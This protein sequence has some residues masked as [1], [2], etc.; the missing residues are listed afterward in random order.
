MIMNTFLIPVILD[1]SFLNQDAFVSFM[2]QESDLPREDSR[3][4]EIPDYN[5]ITLVH[6]VAPAWECILNNIGL[7]ALVRWVIGTSSTD[8]YSKN[9]RR[10]LTAL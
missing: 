2:K 9:F 6:D 3:E 8:H 1:I 5:L 4:K 10:K 7:S